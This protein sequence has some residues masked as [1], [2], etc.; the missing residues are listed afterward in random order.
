MKKLYKLNF[1]GYFLLLYIFHLILSFTLYSISHSNFLTNLHNSEGIWNPY[2]DVFTYHI[3]AIRVASYFENNQIGLVEFITNQ[4]PDT[5]NNNKH[6]KWLALIYWLS[7]FKSYFVFSFITSAI[8]S[9]CIIFTA[10]ISL[11]LFNDI[12][13]ALI[14]TTFFFFP[15]T[16]TVFTQPM[17][18]PFYYLFFVF[19]FFFL[20]SIYKI[21]YKDIFIDKKNNTKSNY[22]GNINIIINLNYKKYASLSFIFLILFFCIQL[23]LFSREYMIDIIY[24]SLFLF[25]LYFTIRYLTILPSKFNKILFSIDI[26]L[27]LFF[28]ITFLV[29]SSVNIFQKSNKY[30]EAKLIQ[31]VKEQVIKEKKIKEEDI[32]V[33]KNIIT[34]EN[35]I[36]ETKKIIDIDCPED[37][38]YD[39]ALTESRVPIIDLCDKKS[40]STFVLSKLN[41]IN[42]SIDK[43]LYKIDL[44]YQTYTTLIN[45]RI[46]SLRYGFISM[47]GDK[48]TLSY[49]LDIE[50]FKDFR[51][52]MYYV[53]RATQIGFFSPFPN[54]I[55][56]SDISVGTTIGA[57][58]M[59]VYYI[60]YLGS[61][62]YLFKNFNSFNPALPLFAI[63]I[64][65]MVL[66]AFI[67]P[68]TGTLY[69]LR[70]A[71]LLVFYIYGIK[72]FLEIIQNFQFLKRR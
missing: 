70:S 59:L 71:Y 23:L 30:V 45:V 58:E 26:S 40:F 72:G 57:V 6:I 56:K 27:I 50:K 19:F 69:R 54:A 34:D 65:V 35:T 55:F 53:P 12:K 33:S 36:I 14:S 44:L 16:I 37:V 18:D 9:I 5:Y 29:I 48:P 21:Y 10:K 25:I 39:P 22:Y 42:K 47:Y 15:T 32:A 49:D 64:L 1:L 52:I 43:I 61:F 62:Y 11:L 7:G 41:T 68:Y 3:Q 46:S 13:L 28:V 66:L 20:V 63:C 8:W 4:I 24:I 2:L 31:T 51:D 38:S 67:I 17:R 60:L